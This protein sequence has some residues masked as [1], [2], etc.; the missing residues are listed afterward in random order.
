MLSQLFE[1]LWGLIVPE[2][3]P[4]CADP[5]DAGFCRQCRAELAVNRDA[6]P[7]CGIGPLAPGAACCDTHPVA[8][9]TD[10]VLS[11]YLFREPLERYIYGLKFRGMRSLGR[12]CGLLLAEAAYARRTRVDAL[13]AVPLHAR[14][15]LE[16]GYNQALEIA[17][18]VSYILKQP[19]LRAGILRA[20]ATSPQTLLGADERRENLQAAFEIRRDLRGLRLA[21]IDDVI[22]TGA[23]A[24][25]LALALRAAGAVYVE[26]WA[27]ARTAR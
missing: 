24:N 22:T 15:L 19:I 25:A 12:A 20:R 13:V 11:P 5:T 26:A 9:Q 4:R 21:I 17:R 6:C 10:A 18:P 14:R 3:C 23:T 2:L 16:R 8:W 27:V 7:I 1:P